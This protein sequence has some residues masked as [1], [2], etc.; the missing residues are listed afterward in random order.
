MSRADRPDDGDTGSPPEPPLRLQDEGV[1]LTGA[2]QRVA[3]AVR[4]EKPPASQWALGRLADLP[5]YGVFVSLKRGKQLRSCCGYLG[6]TMTLAT[7]LDYAAVR[8][9]T[10]DPR[11]PPICEDEL[12]D[13]RIEV[14]ILWGCRKTAERG[15]ARVR[16]IEIGRHGVQITSSRGRGLLL[17]SVAVE[18][19]FDA[20]EF[21]EAV[22]RKAGLPP[23]AWLDDDT[24]LYVFEGRSAAAPLARFIA[25][26]PPVWKGQF[27]PGDAETIA[28]T[29]D[30]WSAAQRVHQPQRWAAAMVPHAG[31][32]YSGQLAFATLAEIDFPERTV[33]FCPRHTGVGP[34]WAVWPGGDWLVPGA[35]VR[36]DPMWAARMVAEIDE[37]YLDD[38]PHCEEHAIEV[39]VPMLARL[40]PHTRITGITIGMGGLEELLRFG[41][42]L[43]L[44]AAALP[45]P[46]LWII[47]SDMHHRASDAE[48]R[49]FDELVLEFLEAADPVGLYRTVVDRRITMCGAAAAVIVLESLRQGGRPIVCRRVGHTTSAEASGDRFNCVGYAGLL[50]GSPELGTT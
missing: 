34:R 24:T 44:V 49:R 8:A 18:H 11:F 20:A 36:S 1:L 41:R 6:E 28:A 38:E 23:N 16:A 4:R 22:C 42:Q 27:Y 35:R 43:A 46:P 33:I 30:R 2:A 39:L 48:T 12:E 45:E 14:W 50:Y 9:A 5:V 10:D 13:L 19:G 40:A 25:P 17:P 3:A 7:A 37:L 47:S 21:L 32:R 15:A 31:W 29:L 26:R